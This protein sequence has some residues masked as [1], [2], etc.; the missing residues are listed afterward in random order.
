[1]EKYSRGLFEAAAGIS[2]LSTSKPDP[3]RQ[4][5]DILVGYRTTS[6][7]V[8]LKSTYSRKFNRKGQFQFPVEQS[9]VDSWQGLT[10]P[11]RMVVYLLGPDPEEWC[12]PRT[13]GELHRTKAYWAT[14]DRSVSVPSVTIDR[15]NRF[16]PDT[17]TAWGAE[18]E[19]G[20]G[21]RHE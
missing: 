17:L 8:Q 12:E 10:I 5:I 1:M 18:I 3:D 19:A 14:L 15:K 16:T 7:A 2:K 21:V 11:P 6:L 9:W 4:G 20:M 13:D